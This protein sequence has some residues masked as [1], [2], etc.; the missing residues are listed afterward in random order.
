MSE[1]F[2]HLV[3]L[4]RPA[5][6]KSEF[7]D[8]MTHVP[9]D[10]RVARYHLGE[11]QVVDDFVFLWAKF[12]EDDIWERLGRPRQ[13]SA[14]SDT[15]GYMVTDDIL[16]SFLIEK[17]NQV[18]ADRF[19]AQGPAY[20]HDHTVLIEFS[21][22]GEAAYRQALGRLSQQVLAQAAI[23]YIDVSFEESLR[24]NRDRYD[25]D[26]PDSI[27]AHSVPVD[28]MYSIYRADD[29]RELTGAK[30]A[31][32]LSIH[33]LSVPY[34]TMHNEPESTDPAVLEMRYGEALDELKYLYDKRPPVML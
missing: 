8:F 26:Q 2:D 5:C 14:P 31:G 23:L 11:F 18:I 34:V 15:G 3:A 29:W 7:I 12:E 24:R 9:P 25:E 32:Y 17:V 16:W 13:V 33:G 20:Y 4:G 6:G 27:L 30:P 21:R 28:T 22:G 10:E 19:L 1:T